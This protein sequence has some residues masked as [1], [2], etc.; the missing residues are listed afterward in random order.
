M[1][2][3]NAYMALSGKVDAEVIRREK[4][5]HRTT[6]RI[7][8]PAALFVIPRT[9]QALMRTFEVLGTEG[10]PWI[11]LGRGSN[12]L[13]ADEGYD[14]CVIKLGR[15]FSRIESAGDG[16]LTAGAGALLNTLLSQ[17]Q[18]AG[19]SGLEILTGVPGTVGGAVSMN[20]GMR[21]EWIGSRVESVVTVKP[22]EGMR[23]YQG[24]D[25]EWDY[26]WCS[27]PADE[28][29]LEA[30]FALDPA[31]KDRIASEMESRLARRRL[32]QPMGLPSCGSVFRNPPHASAGRLVEE[33]GLSGFTVGGAQISETHANFIVNRGGAKAADVVSC[34]QKMHDGV[35]TS[36][37]IDLVP[38]VK[39]L[40]FGR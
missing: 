37:G 14:G 18:Q 26:R 22:R 38:E 20:A 21:S 7:G 3:F 30:T 39:L 8:G 27:L 24:I 32:R 9:Y 17:A 34:M 11:V 23:R 13:V 36:T 15:E 33:C 40:G 28:V 19:L 10:V 35:L 12:V 31:D 25:I 16:R 29:I 5:S 4:L 1:S 2:V 6:Y